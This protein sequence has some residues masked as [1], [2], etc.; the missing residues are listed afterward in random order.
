[1]DRIVDADDFSVAK[2]TRNMKEMIRT[3]D[4]SGENNKVIV[5]L[6]NKRLLKCE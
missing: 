5:Q 6:S 3:D 1:L 4:L 2:R